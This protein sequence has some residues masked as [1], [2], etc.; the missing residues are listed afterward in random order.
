MPKL[1]YDLFSRRLFR[2]V[3]EMCKKIPRICH[4]LPLW[5]CPF[6]VRFFS[7]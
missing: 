1:P 7:Y 4:T 3:S 5:G 2:L 6:P